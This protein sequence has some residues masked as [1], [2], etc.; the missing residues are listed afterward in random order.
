M[1][2]PTTTNGVPVPAKTNSATSA[3]VSPAVSIV[4]TLLSPTNRAAAVGETVS[5]QIAVSNTGDVTLDTVPV[6]DA[7]NS[8]LLSYLDTIPVANTQ[9]VGQITWNNVGALGVG[10]S[11]VVTARFT[12]A[13]SGLSTNFAMTTPTTTNGVP[14]P[15]KTNSVTNATA[16]P[17]FAVV[18]TKTTPVGRNA[19]MGELMT[20]T[21]AVAN[22]GDV[23]LI[24]VPVADSYDTNLLSYVNAAPAP[25]LPTDG[26]LVWGDVGP[27]AVGASTNVVVTMRAVG[28]GFGNNQVIVA[29][30][31]STNQPTVAA[32]TNTVP[33]SNDA[34]LVVVS[35]HGTG[36][37][38]VGVYTNGYGTVL[39]NAM[40]SLV[41]FGGTQYVC[42]GWTLAGGQDTNAQ[43]SGVGTNVTLGLTNNEV[44]TWVWATNYLLNVSS[45]GNGTLSGSTN[46]FYDAGTLVTVIA[47]PLTNYLFAGWTG[48]TAGNSNNPSLNLTMDQARTVVAH[49][50]PNEEALTIVSAH[51]TGTPPVGTHT[52]N[53]GVLLTNAVSGVQTIG[54][55]QYVATGWTLA[56]GADT[57]AQQ[58]GSG[59]NMMLTLT[60]NEVLTWLWATNYLLTTTS[61][62]NGTVSGSTNGFYGSGSNVS[63]TAVP[64]LNY[65]F[66]GWTGDTTGST[67][68]L[69]LNLT[70]DQ[71]RT[72]VAH[73]AHD[74]DTLTIISEHGTG[75]PPVGI[76]TNN[77]NSWL[78]NAITGVQ[79]I[80]G[81]QYVV[82][83][84]MLEG[85]M[86]TNAQLS[87]IGTNCTLVLTNNE[88]LTWLWSTNYYLTLIATN[89]AITNN[90]SGWKPASAL[91]ALYPAPA[92][93]FVFDCWALNGQNV[94]AG[95]PLYVTMSQ[96]QVV[97]AF[98]VQTFVDVS[99]Q[100]D[101]NVKWTFNPRL[102]YFIGS[103]TITNRPAS[104]KALLLPFWY[105]VQSTTNWWLR[106][107]TGLDTNTGYHYLD[108]TAS[109]TNLLV[110]IGNH[111]LW[112][113]PGESVTVTNIAL[114]GRRTPSNDLVIA[115]WADPPGAMLRPADTDGDGV[116]DVNEYISGTSAIDPNAYFH[117][118][119]GP[120]GRS[121]R[122]NGVVGRLYKVWAAT[123]LLQGF[124]PVA[125]YVEGANA[126]ACYAPAPQA[127]GGGT[128]GA[129]F[130][131]IEV[132]LKELSQ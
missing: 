98:F 13:S 22:T 60:N 39:T 34:I 89:G 19:A 30:T 125:D 4:K 128:N 67:N 69:T 100:I 129:V 75:T 3:T 84:W 99:S 40:T 27:L 57:N 17:G 79:T 37:L 83:G 41:T 20:W 102:G 103:L 81:T 112:L 80:G 86:G 15:A 114:M 21:I 61:A 8:V 131:R 88:T 64:S 1:T 28:S 74:T 45:A 122:W 2:T 35:A 104:V 96:A 29:P 115:V 7:Y 109:V 58:V 94:G 54:G 92:F 117:A 78:T 16:A 23:T 73:F 72:I 18:K 6:V 38:P 127:L 101:W 53:Y 24:T 31:T 59:T 51:G 132:R 85:G 113:D 97:Q 130:Y 118:W 120:D 14:V 47:T 93:G 121:V 70:M 105:E 11:T 9:V 124:T 65:H 26:A 25:S 42:A 82:T 106:N 119:I 44:L 123:N 12:V 111:N 68:A 56:G 62:G 55:T 76:Y 49:F 36:A 126:I 116:L 71:A 50:V 66:T 46:G 110:G 5:Y 91:Y 43:P 107:P 63:V 87:G 77:Y 32:K 10:N 48:D 52:N 90:T 108:I 33:F 95:M